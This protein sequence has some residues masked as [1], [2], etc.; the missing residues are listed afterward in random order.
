M[1]HR[2]AQAKSL[3]AVIRAYRDS[4]KFLDLAPSTRRSYDVGFLRAEAKIGDMLVDE[5]NVPIMQE[6]L[7]RFD[8]TAAVKRNARAGFCAMEKWALKRGLMTVPIMHAT[9]AE[10]EAD[11]HEPWTDAQ[12][13]LAETNARP[14]LA[15]LITLGANTGQRGSDLV[16]MK[17]LDIEDYQ[18]RP[19]INVIQ[20]KTGRRLW[21]PF[22]AE[23]IKVIAGWDRSLGYLITK[24]TGQPYTRQHL[25]DAWQHERDHNSA[26]G[27][28][29]AAGLVLHG[30]RA[31]AVVRMRRAGVSRPLIGDFIGMSARMVD[32]YCRASEQRDNALAGLQMM[33]RTE[34]EPNNVVAL[35]KGQPSD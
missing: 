21:V 12:V 28:I 4:A 15:R 11:A 29:K 16:R 19:G 18:G 27:P 22:T 26:L 34:A 35:K 25:S 17:W 7:D 6:F 33:D 8:R 24:P 9:E 2:K 14:D 13:R 31:T 3:S 23:L 20:K 30:L 10:Y 5:L 1:R 32:R